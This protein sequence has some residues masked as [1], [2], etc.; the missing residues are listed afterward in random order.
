M[1][2]KAKQDN[3]RSRHMTSRMMQEEAMPESF[4]PSVGG[5]DK[6]T[7]YQKNIEREVR[8]SKQRRS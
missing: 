6:M 4:F 8:K 3:S 1:L 5:G 7:D 2:A